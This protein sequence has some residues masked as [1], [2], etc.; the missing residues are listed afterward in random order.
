MK[1]KDHQFDTPIVDIKFH[2]ATRNVI[3]S[4]KKIVR[5]WDKDTGNN[6]AHIEPNVDI[7][8][9][10]VLRNSGAFFCSNRRIFFISSILI[11]HSHF[12]V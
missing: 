9:V 1:I 10:C 3:S 8:D 4:C 7:N 11:S 5:I 12:V 6:F 2:E